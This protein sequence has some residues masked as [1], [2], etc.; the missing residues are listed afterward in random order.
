MKVKEEIIE[1]CHWCLED[2]KFDK[3]NSFLSC[4]KH[5]QAVKRFLN[6]LEK[7]KD[8]KFSY[9]FDEDE[10]ERVVKFFSLLRHSKGVLAGSPIKLTLWQKFIVCQLE[11]W[12]LKENKKLRRFNKSFIEVAR[13]NAKSQL[14]SGLALYEASVYA[15]Q[16]GDMAEIYTAGIKREQSHIVFDECKS[17]LNNSP[18][19]LK[20]NT[21]RDKIEHKKTMSIIKALAKEDSKTGDGASP[22][23]TILDEYHLHKDTGFYDLHTSGCKARISPMLCV[24]TTAGFNLQNPCYTQEYP[25]CAKIL[26]GELENDRYFVDIL[27]LDKNDEI[28]EENLVKANPI[29]C[30]YEMGYNGL[31]DD[32]KVANDVP[33]KMISFKTK[34]CNIWVDGDTSVNKYMDMDKFKK[35]KVSELPYEMLEGQQCYIGL[36]LSSKWDL[37]GVSFEIPWKEEDGTVK[38]YIKTHNFVPNLE[39]LREHE[40]KEKKPYTYWMERGW[41]STTDSPIVDQ[42]VVIDYALEECK[43]HNWKIAMFCFDP[44]NASTTEMQVEK[45]GY[46]VVEVYQSKKSLNESTVNFKEQ[47]EC[48]NIIYEENDL[49]EY[50]MA[51]AIIDMNSDGLMKIDKSNVNN[52]IDSVDATLCSHKLSIYHEFKIDLEKEIMADDFII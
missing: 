17:M 50:Q 20:F 18:L 11:G 46:G 4:V 43:K 34:N 22:Q 27:E 1:Y 48:D 28:N 2:K 6:D 14:E 10:A 31:L 38:Y 23:L 36:D 24:I 51:N 3:Y 9:Y 12:R 26:D 47:V 13:K 19:K 7:S 33:E 16:L 52:K 45:L 35:C 37:T 49:Y 41:I 29:V 15:T 25:Y 21:T 8:E 44:H 5:K 40:E 42:Q 30:S 32:M 39:K